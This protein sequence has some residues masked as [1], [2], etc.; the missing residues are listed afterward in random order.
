[1]PTYKV[2]LQPSQHQFLAS[3]KQ[4]LLHAGLEA[5]LNLR[6]GCDGGNCGECMAHLL[7]GEIQPI[8]HSDYV[9]SEAEKQQ[10][11]FLSCCFSAASDLEIEMPEIG[12]VQELCEQRIQARVYKKQLLSD[13]VMAVYFK[14]PR[15]QPLHFLAGQ[16]VRIKIN[17]EL[18]RNKSIASCPCDSLKPEF[19]IQ[20]RPGDPFSDYMFNQLKKGD[21]VEIK[22]PC[23]KFVLDDDSSRPLVLIAFDT[24]FA[25]IKSLI[26]HAIALEKEQ[27]IDLYWILTPGHDAYLENYCRSVQHA[28]DNFNYQ[29]IMIDERSDETVSAVLQQ[30]LS[31]QKAIR[32][33]DIYVTLPAE[34]RK[35]AKQQLIAAGIDDRHWRIDTIKKL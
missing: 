6:F 15:S 33:S 23:G 22:G 7:R 3:S 9:Y 20:R 21:T 16:H 12:N 8:R 18:Q 29:C 25:S 1:M 13:S 14:M 30:I 34:F 35:L 11:A 27:P 26:E 28:L 31:G 32:H 5:G 10:K 2:T 19:H 24:G 17:D 4:S